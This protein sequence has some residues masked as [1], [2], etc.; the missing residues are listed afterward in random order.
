MGEAK[1]KAAAREK[2][3]FE[4][5]RAFVRQWNS[6]VSSCQHFDAGCEWE[7]VRIAGALSI[8]CNDGSSPSLLTLIDY[9]REHQGR[10]LDTAGEVGDT[11][12]LDDH[13]LVGF[14]IGTHGATIT[15]FLDGVPFDGWMKFGKWWNAPVVRF[16][17]T[18][19]K[20]SRK[21]LVIALRNTEGY[22]HFTKKADPLIDE[23]GEDAPVRWQAFKDG[24]PE[25]IK[26]DI[27]SSSVRQIGH[28]LVR[29]L[30]QHVPFLVEQGIEY[31]KNLSVLV[32]NV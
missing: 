19:Q 22:G 28:E 3:K 8:F 4:I 31:P 14:S 13:P 17:S 20:Y 21:Q 16:A 9:G 7:L 1:N 32:R 2:N 11:N 26:G 5:E 27:L 6:L 24:Q 15:H 18:G 29:S 25:K 10:L 30:E 12:L 23:I